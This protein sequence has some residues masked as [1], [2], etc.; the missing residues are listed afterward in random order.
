MTR[1]LDVP[2]SRNACM[3]TTLSYRSSRQKLNRTIAFTDSHVRPDTIP[4]LLGRYEVLAL[5]LELF[6]EVNFDTNTQV[7]L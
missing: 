2:Q 1:K 6:T 3:L 7:A 5:I 4:P